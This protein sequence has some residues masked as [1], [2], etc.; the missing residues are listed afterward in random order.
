M[1][2]PTALQQQGWLRVRVRELELERRATDADWMYSEARRAGGGGARAGGP[3]GICS[4]RFRP[5][6]SCSGLVL[7]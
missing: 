3:A 1:A 6:R 5:V 2:P 4:R 7:D